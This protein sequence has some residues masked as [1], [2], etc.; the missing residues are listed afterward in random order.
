MKSPTFLVLIPLLLTACATPYQ[1]SGAL[2]GYSEKKIA[3]NKYELQFLGNALTDMKV[4]HEF[5]SRRDSLRRTLRWLCPM[6]F[7]YLCN[8]AIPWPKAQLNA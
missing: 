6:A 1:A 7:L 2:G 5:W 4:I 8:L 3:E